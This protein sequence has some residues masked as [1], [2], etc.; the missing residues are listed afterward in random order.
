MTN[1]AANTTALA[2]RIDRLESRQAIRD[3]VSDYCHGFDKREFERFLAIWWQDCSWDIG[4]PFG[5]FSDHDGI[6]TAIHDVLWPAWAH[7][8]H[9]TTNL[10]VAFEDNNHATG[11]SDVH[12][13]GSLAGETT[14]TV[15]GASYF[16]HYERRGDTWKILR[17]AVTI[18]YFNPVPG[19]E[20]S[21][22]AGD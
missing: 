20:L 19:A 16:D 12:C 17:R 6:R 1:A 4:P 8:L 9:L 7:S 15:V 5:S 10:R 21:P 11:V 3:L 14:C 22:P 18:H 13:V 2:A